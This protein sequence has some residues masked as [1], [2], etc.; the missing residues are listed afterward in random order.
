MPAS[1]LRYADCSNAL[2]GTML[3]EYI[4]LDRSVPLN[5]EAEVPKQSLKEPSLVA[6]ASPFLMASA[7]DAPP[8]IVEFK[9]GKRVGHRPFRHQHH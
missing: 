6:W 1:S 5:S 3:I 2:P 7:N 9:H 8:F 4:G